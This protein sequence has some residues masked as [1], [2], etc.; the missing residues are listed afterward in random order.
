VCSTGGVGGVATATLRN[1][2]ENNGVV[3]RRNN[4][5]SGAYTSGRYTYPSGKFL[6]PITYGTGADA[7]TMTDHWQTVPRHYWKVSVEWCD[8]Q[9]SVVGDRWNKYGT[10]VNGTCQVFKD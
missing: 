10:A 8:Q 5:T 1:D 3:C 9:I 4:K 7:C 6:T 2:A